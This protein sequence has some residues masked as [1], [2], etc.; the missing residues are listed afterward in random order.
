MKSPLN[1]LMVEDSLDD[2]QLILLQ[3]EQEGIEV[4]YRRVDTEEAFIEALASPPDLILSDFSMPKFSGLE[5]LKILKKL[6]LDIPFI[7]ISGTIGEEVAVEAMKDGADDYLMK[8]RLIRLGTAIQIAL[9]QKQLRDEKTQA[10]IALR[11][12][13]ARFRSLIENGVDEISII[14]A[15][16]SLMYESPSANPPLGYAKGEFL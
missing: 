13:E 8:D 10:D 12:N 2:V 7:L 15:D 4:Q 5:A 14:A 6:S 1:I 16:G 11:N 3:L 9:K